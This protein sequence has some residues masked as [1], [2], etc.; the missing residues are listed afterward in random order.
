MSL[1]TRVSSRLRQGGNVAELRQR[2]DHFRV[3]LD[4]NNRVLE[5][6]ADAG[7]KLS[8]EYLFDS[9]YLRSLTGDLTQAVRSVVYNLE[10]VTGDR[11]PELVAGI[12]E[13]DAKFRDLL[14]SR[15]TVPQTDYVIPLDRVD[16]ELSDAVGDKMARLGEIRRCLECTVPEGFV[17]SANACHCYLEEL[18]IEPEAAAP[19]SDIHDDRKLAEW[20]HDLAGRVRNAAVPRKI[21][22]EIVRAA[23]RLSKQC[24]GGSLA[25]RSSAIGE[26]GQTSFAGLYE[27]VLGVEPDQLLDAYR[28]VVAG[29][30]SENVMSYRKRHGIYPAQGLMAVGCM[31]M[32]DAAAGGVLYSLDPS[33]PERDVFMVTATL[34]LG[35]TVVEG[36]APVDTFEISRHS[37]HDVVRRSIAHK[38]NEYVV[39]DDHRLRLVRVGESLRDVPAVT[40]DTLQQLAVLALRIERYMKRAQ[41]I[42]WAVDR[43]GHIYVLQV[44]PLRITEGPQRT[45]WDIGEAVSRYPVLMQGRGV[46][47][48]RG[49]ASGPIHLVSEPTD[50]EPP[51]EAVLVARTS[52]PRLAALLADASAVITDVGTPTGHLATIAREFRV[53]TIVDAGIA[54]AVLEHG[55]EV[56][57]DAEE[58]VIYGGR[59]E[60]LL[61]HQLL[62]SSSF[63]ERPEFHMLRKILKAAAPLNLKDP[64]SPEFAA[65]NCKTYH[66]IVRFAHELA[67]QELTHGRSAKVSKAGTMVHRLRLTVP[68]DLILIDLGDGLGSCGG[69]ESIDRDAVVSQPLCALL[70]GLTTE[71]VWATAPAD[72]DLRGFMASV[73]RTGAPGDPVA[74]TPV[75]NLAIVSAN[76]LHLDLRLGYHFNVIDCYLDDERNHNYIYFRFA[77]GVTEIT[78]RSR[79]ARV[80]KSILEQEDFVTE[81]KGDL[82]IGRIKKIS[83]D[84]MVDR[85]QVIGRLIGFTRQLDILLRDDGMVDRCVR[86]FFE[87][88]Y[89]PVSV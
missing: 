18:G 60:E 83:R 14:Q 32:V 64:E 37:P 25:V 10:G 16:Q 6:I 7:E 48:S 47:A 59:V 31:E 38:E 36:S 86:S 42:E 51:P 52:S 89:D 63:E 15:L 74:T 12:S 72:M 5:L 80:L 55:R 54:S 62:R 24:G 75:R 65:S 3:L 20:S 85:L 1:W 44:R 41:D 88:R 34:G 40:D 84:E 17:I 23:H 82:V 30:Y 26:D 81:G 46:V 61:H 77:G 9:Q 43:N 13:I 22:K 67:V 78:R 76:Y 19:T 66:D 71:G 8:G 27:S 56:T 50:A 70:D 68:L 45:D 33:R 21:A 2:L 35:K 39:G 57:V 49:I 58:N 69:G 73:T 28:R 79:R 87:G 4:G 11:Y 53:P 29:L